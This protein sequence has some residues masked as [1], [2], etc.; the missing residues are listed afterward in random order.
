[1]SLFGPIKFDFPIYAIFPHFKWS[2]L[3]LKDDV[4]NEMH[5]RRIE[6]VIYGLFILASGLESIPPPDLMCKVPTVAAV[7]WS[8]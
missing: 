3:W 4:G 8:F 6:R 2:D 7:H 5:S 1:M